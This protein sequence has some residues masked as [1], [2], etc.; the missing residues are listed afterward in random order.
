MAI[1]SFNVPGISTVLFLTACGVLLV[2]LTEVPLILI[3][4]RPY[5]DAISPSQFIE[6]W[7]GAVTIISDNSTTNRSSVPTISTT[8]EAML[9][10]AKIDH[11]STG[12]TATSVIA[13]ASTTVTQKN[14]T[15]FV[16]PDCST[17][18]QDGQN[19]TFCCA[20]SWKHDLDTWWRR[21][22]DFEVSLENETTFC[23]SPIREVERAIFLKE[24]LYPQQWLSNCSHTTGRQLV[25][26]GFSANMGL[27]SRMFLSSLNH[28][29]TFVIAKKDDLYQWPYSEYDNK[30][31]V[32]DSAD[33]QCY[34]LPVTNCNAESGQADKATGRYPFETHS[35]NIWVREYMMRPKQFM[36]RKIYELLQKTPKPTLPCAAMHVRRTDA[37]LENWINKRNYFELGDYVSKLAGP[38]RRQLATYFKSVVLLT[39]DQSVI[40]ESHEFHATLPWIYVNRTRH[41]GIEGGYNGHKPSGDPVHEIAVILA[42]MKLARHCERLIFTKS[43]Y[44]DLL[45]QAMQIEQF[46]QKKVTQIKIDSNRQPDKKLKNAQSAE[47]FFAKLDAKRAQ[48]GLKKAN[49]TR[50]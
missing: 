25:K 21:H 27:L 33:M 41:R 3:T 7:F 50:S 26:S 20:S 48:K 18:E 34:F 11:N 37:I 44:K 19:R 43:G 24:V 30:T 22:P 46:D 42:E 47:A 6:P 32:C 17:Y 14:K 49:Q 1:R 5:F 39:D 12:P 10:S 9:L 31:K 45:I 13:T 16:Y 23:F 28:S 15:P 4:M 38:R 35:P 8:N 29:S 36:R 2:S 40:E